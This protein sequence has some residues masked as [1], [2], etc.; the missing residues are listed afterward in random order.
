M[1]GNEYYSDSDEDLIDTNIKRAMQLYRQNE[2][3]HQFTYSGGKDFKYATTLPKLEMD[4]CLLQALKNNAHNAQNDLAL[5]PKNDTVNYRF[6]AEQNSLRNFRGE[7]LSRSLYEANKHISDTVDP[8]DAH[9]MDATRNFEYVL[10]YTV[11][12]KHIEV[13]KKGEERDVETV[14]KPI[15]EIIKSEREMFL[16]KKKT[17]TDIVDFIHILMEQE[18]SQQYF[19]EKSTFRSPD[20]LKNKLNSFHT[21]LSKGNTQGKFRFLSS[22]ASEEHT[23]RHAMQETEW[24]ELGQ[25]E[26][27]CTRNIVMPSKSKMYQNPKV[28]TKMTEDMK[29]IDDTTAMK[30]DLVIHMEEDEY[31]VETTF[32]LH[33]LIPD[34]HLVVTCFS[35]SSE[36][37]LLTMP[38]DLSKI[39]AP[40]TQPTARMWE[41]DAQI[42]RDELSL[43]ELHGL[44][45]KLNLQSIHMTYDID[46]NNFTKPAVKM[47]SVGYVYPY[48]DYTII[49]STTAK[50]LNHAEYETKQ[51]TTVD[52]D[53]LNYNATLYTII[54]W[55]PRAQFT[56]R[57]QR[58]IPPPRKPISS[59]LD[60]I[61]NYMYRISAEYDA[62]MPYKG[63]FEQ[64]NDDRAVIMPGIYKKIGEYQKY[65][66]TVVIKNCPESASDIIQYHRKNIERDIINDLQIGKGKIAYDYIFKYL[67]GG[68]HQITPYPG[69][70]VLYLKTISEEDPGDPAK[71]KHLE[72]W[73]DYWVDFFKSRR[74]KFPPYSWVEY[75]SHVLEPII[76]NLEDLHAIKIA[77]KK[78]VKK[79]N[80]SVATSAP[81]LQILNP[82]F[83][84]DYPL[85][86]ETVKKTYREVRN[87]ASDRR[88]RA[89][90]Q[91]DGDA[92]EHSQ[93]LIR[94]LTQANQSGRG[95]GGGY[96]GGGGGRGGYGGRGGGYGGRGSYTGRGGGYGGRSNP[97]EPV[98]VKPKPAPNTEKAK[99]SKKADKKP[100]ESNDSQGTWRVV[101]DSSTPVQ[102]V[103]PS[104][105][106]LEDAT[107]MFANR[108]TNPQ[109]RR[110]KDAPPVEERDLE[111][112]F[113]SQIDALKRT[114]N[115]LTLRSQLTPVERDRLRHT[116]Q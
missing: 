57:R 94:R 21:E 104:T 25:F 28:I 79:H 33:R 107:G 71:S 95:G 24:F 43:L 32:T 23:T 41:V 37:G 116:L 7:Y 86:L 12:R 5:D 22:E 4:T 87:H 89:A 34:R 102:R 62:L 27:K 82:N 1:Q 15:R 46:V 74:D 75:T 76:S 77:Y 60:K 49:A 115:E 92:D 106:A 47:E 81:V 38:D 45:L 30:I 96:G 53:I 48:T 35:F 105:A 10:D 8:F 14:I 64:N 36:K 52:P 91:R 26:I 6:M 42:S 17:S 83:E 63:I 111:S 3:S 114:V 108:T 16:D 93:D 113:Q 69:M 2:S 98:F 51:N 66:G 73:S 112:Q 90:E 11:H 13:A 50:P 58:N 29:S 88:D 20:Q 55:N 85:L 109:F 9:T 44:L 103:G 56:T 70:F 19:S 84:A 97:N 67:S 72:K 78:S 110:P 18:Y 65:L 80:S 31:I 40:P 100:G 54:H 68:G 101:P 59:E 61:K 99:R 39:K